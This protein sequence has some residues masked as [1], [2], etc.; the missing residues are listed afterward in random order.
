[1][2]RTLTVGIDI[3]DVLFPWYDLAHEASTRAGITNGITPTSW[4]PFTQYGCTD[5]EWFDVLSDALHDGMYEHHPIPGAVDALHRI[6][7]AGHSIHIVTAR[8]L[9]NHGLAIKA[10]TVAWIEAHDVPHV[11]LHFTGDKTMVRTDVFIDD[12]PRHVEGL[13]AIGVPTWLVD[14]PYNQDCPHPRRVT[15]ISEF[16]DS[17]IYLGA[18]R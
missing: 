14:R 6:A 13:E 8:G 15:H 1:M 12:H 16:A 7:D 17:V 9:L 2:T 4:A 11:G 5:Q 18:D 10:A 3:D